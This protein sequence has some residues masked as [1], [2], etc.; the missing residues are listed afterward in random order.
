MTQEFEKKVNGI[1]KLL[2]I[3]SVV[4][5]SCVTCDGLGCV[6]VC[7]NSVIKKVCP[8]CGGMGK[9]VVD[10]KNEST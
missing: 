3:R 5:E 2:N 7:D 9:I 6:P 4:D 10:N 1:R 8:D